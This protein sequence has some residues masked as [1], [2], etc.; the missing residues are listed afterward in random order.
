MH[1]ADFSEVDASNSQFRHCKLSGATCSRGN[2]TKADFSFAEMHGNFN[3]ADL[4]HANLYS[5]DLAASD[6]SHS[7]LRESVM[8]EAKIQ[9]ADFTFAKMQGSIGTNGKPWGVA[10]VKVVS[11]KPWWQVWGRNAAM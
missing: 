8:T 7:D 11:K 1:L 3:H 2:F 5:C 10:A 4:N 6:F 9:Q